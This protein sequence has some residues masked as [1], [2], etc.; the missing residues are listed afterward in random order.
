MA[1]MAPERVGDVRHVDA[2]HRL[3]QL[4]REVDRGAVAAGGHVEP[5]WWAY[6]DKVRHVVDA[7]GLAVSVFI[8]I[9]LGTPATSVMGAK[10]FCGS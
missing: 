4:A 8:T 1:I 3:E 7:Q 10:S 6:A 2:G 5:A 9:T